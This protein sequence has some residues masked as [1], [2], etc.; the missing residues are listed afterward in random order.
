LQFIINV[1]DILKTLLAHKRHKPHSNYIKHLNV[2][3]KV[4]YH[5]F[6]SQHITPV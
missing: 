6:S 2:S 3:K 5:R 4:T 1:P